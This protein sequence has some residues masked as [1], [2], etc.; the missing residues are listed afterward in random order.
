MEVGRLRLAAQGLV[1]PHDGSPVEVV[2]RLGAVQGQDLAGALLSVALRTSD[3][4]LEAVHASFDRAELVR[5]WPMRGTLHV[6][7]AED[8]G[9]MLSLTAPRAPID[10]RERR[11]RRGIDENMIKKAR[12]AVVE[13]LAESGGLTRAELLARVAAQGVDPSNYRGYL[14]LGMLAQE[15]LVCFG[16]THGGTDQKLVL[17]DGWIGSP[18]RLDGTAAIAELTMRYFVGHGPATVADLVRWS[19][20]RV[21]E[22]RAGLEEIGDRLVRV[23]LDGQE[24]WMDPDLGDGPPRSP[25]GVFLLPGFD[26]FVLGYRDRTAVLP[27]EHADKIV[28]GGNGVFRPT[29]VHR[30]RI[31][32]TWAHR[33]RGAKRRLV[34]EPF[35]DLPASVTAKV[36]RAYAAL[37]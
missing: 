21:R 28:P 3:R 30:G 16:P 8:L 23:E 1:P 33:G 5:S 10:T 9:W 20:L 18:R 27:N 24:H 22:V 15:G 2:R 6:V 34:F 31:I 25:A 26:E 37:P 12:R 13:S 11:E 36:E 35:G 17:V 7:P 19:G 32:G 29:V 4:S 14:L